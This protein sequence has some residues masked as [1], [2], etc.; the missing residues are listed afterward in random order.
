MNEERSTDRLA[1]YM[2]WAAVTAI[3]TRF[4]SGL[5]PIR[6]LMAATDDN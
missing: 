2:I 4:F 1:R 3:A 6:R 5:K